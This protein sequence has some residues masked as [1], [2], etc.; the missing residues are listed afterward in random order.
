MSL[1]LKAFL[2]FL[3]AAFIPFVSILVVYQFDQDPFEKVAYHAIT[4]IRINKQSQVQDHMNSL[5]NTV[6]TL[7]EGGIIRQ[8]FQSFQNSLHSLTLKTKQ[9][10]AELSRLENELHSWYEYS[11]LSKLNLLSQKN[12]KPA[13]LLPTDPLSLYLQFEYLRKNPFSFWNHS[14]YSG[15]DI[16]LPYHQVHK[17]YHPNLLEWK[18]RFNLRDLFL[19]NAKGRIL[20]STDKSVLFGRSIRNFQNHSPALSKIYLQIAKN[21]RDAKLLT[22]DFHPEL[23]SLYEPVCY[24][25]APLLIEE[26]EW[27]ILVFSI[28]SSQL[29]QILNG[30]G[31]WKEE[32]LGD[33]GE[34]YIVSYDGHL[35]SSSRMYLEQSDKL[36]SL[37][38]PGT[39]TMT[40]PAAE[41]RKLSSKSIHKARQGKTGT[42]IIKNPKGTSLISSYSPMKI[43]GLD[44]IIITEIT[45]E[46]ALWG[47]DILY[48][49][50]LIAGALFLA[51]LLLVHRLVSKNILDPI[52]YLA[53]E[54]Q[55]IAEGGEPRPRFIEHK[56]EIGFLQDSFQK[57]STR[58]YTA[59]RDL[60]W[61]ISVSKMTSEKLSRSQ[62][63]LQKVLERI[64]LSIFWKDSNQKYLGANHSFLDILG[65]KNQELIHLHTNQQIPISEWN[66]KVLSQ[67]EEQFRTLGSKQHVSVDRLKNSEGT[68][69]WHT[70]TLLSLHNENG[71]VIGTLGL[72]EDLTE[73]IRSEDELMVVQQLKSLDTITGGIAHEFR[74]VLHALGGNITL[75]EKVKDTKPFKLSKYIKEIRGLLELATELSDKLLTITKTGNLPE[76]TSTIESII[77]SILDSL[78]AEVETN[79]SLK[80]DPQIRSVS[81]ER[82]PLHQ[83]TQNLVL[84]AVQAMDFK[85][86]LIIEALHNHLPSPNEFNL[87][88][89]DYLELKIEDQGGGIPQ[90]IQKKIFDPFYSARDGGSGFGLSTVRTLVL[91]MKGRIHLQSKPS[92]GTI[93]QVILPLGGSGNGQETNFEEHREFLPGKGKILILD[94][95]EIILK[96][97]QDLLEILGYE[98]YAVTTGMEAVQ[99]HQ[100]EWNRKKPF[101]ALIIDYNLGGEFDG[102]KALQKIRE[103]DKDFS[104]ILSTAH[105]DNPAYL[106]FKE[107]GFDSAIRKPHD[108]SELSRI[109]W[110]LLH[111]HQS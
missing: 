6:L 47:S 64:P 27:G 69:V 29:N 3:I 22:E 52:T 89:G 1:K 94:D 17:Q 106:N 24:L 57:M 13:D 33:S 49:Q 97:T 72:L 31:Q 77:Q 56:D 68:L 40:W 98:V 38:N 62:T 58:L 7:S 93:F 11:F 43:S 78:M 103:I 79:F 42:E 88:E 51:L 39:E 25:A 48:V 15:P 50:L 20:Y 111:N 41:Y 109:L 59:Q 104:A 60:E 19:I 46:E 102:V 10:D 81:M 76:K 101:D 14:S 16:P 85:G 110:E 105:L 67:V 37:L 95:R 12:F 63:L 2:L 74:N 65:L 36:L 55:H 4:S 34:S 71:D 30:G 90:E 8:A 26:G 61:E 84:N 45:M 91:K 66:R 75:V 99:T 87:P 86:E 23:S 92:V 108:M 54:S 9:E 70:I 82:L 96:S 83:I 44:W 73:K 28:D 35:R 21:P 100:N 53:E 32:G 18:E 80:I 5:G 107:Y